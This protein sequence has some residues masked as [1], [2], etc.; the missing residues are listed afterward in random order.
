MKKELGKFLL[1]LGKI[2]FGGAILTRVV[3][4]ETFSDNLIIGTFTASIVF[5]VFFGLILIKKS[6]Q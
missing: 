2:M 6:E 3:K 1:D 4:N 5:I